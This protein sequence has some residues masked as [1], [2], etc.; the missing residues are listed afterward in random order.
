MTWATSTRRFRLP[1]D[2]AE[3]RVRIF[4]RDKYRCQW[5]VNKEPREICGVL[6]TDIDHIERGDRHEDSNLQAL[7][8]GHHNHKSA[9]EGRQAQLARAREIKKQ[10]ARPQEK[11]P[12]LL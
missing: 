9:V 7:C 8:R 6:A 1:P 2:W 3:I 5:I 10:F 12:G 11:H 4:E